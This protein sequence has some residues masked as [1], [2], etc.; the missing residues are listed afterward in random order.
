MRAMRAS[1]GVG[2]SS[3]QQRSLVLSV[4]G[5]VFAASLFALL[6]GNTRPQ[7][8][9]G[10]SNNAAHAP[11]APSLNHNSSQHAL[12]PGTITEHGGAA[13]PKM[14]KVTIT[15]SAPLPEFI[16]CPLAKG[17]FHVC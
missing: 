6:H 12:R 13:A 4:T 17:V 16:C 3:W 9:P 8:V 10:R 1:A 15:P 14:Q 5:L 2:T 11:S 7:A